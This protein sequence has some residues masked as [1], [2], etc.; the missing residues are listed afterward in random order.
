MA[1][2]NLSIAGSSPRVRPFA[3]DWQDAGS[4]GYDIAGK[5]HRRLELLN[6]RKLLEPGFQTVVGGVIGCGGSRCSM[7]CQD[8]IQKATIRQV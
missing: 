3:K 2:V 1:P 8:R 7:W 5:Y 4:G 6:N